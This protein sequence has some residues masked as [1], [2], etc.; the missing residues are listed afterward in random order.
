MLRF[1]IRM[2]F[3]FFERD[4][5]CEC[6]KKLTTFGSENYVVTGEQLLETC[7]ELAVEHRVNDLLKKNAYMFCLSSWQISRL[8]PNSYSWDTIFHKH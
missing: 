8:I 3:V 5:F 2:Y 4:F 6:C 7:S 1:V